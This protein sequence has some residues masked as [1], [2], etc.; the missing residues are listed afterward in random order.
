MHTRFD[1]ID[2]DDVHEISIPELLK[3]TVLQART[4]KPAEE[5]PVHN[6]ERPR[7]KLG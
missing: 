2:V 6:A 3:S 1:Y 7:L 4:T 5:H